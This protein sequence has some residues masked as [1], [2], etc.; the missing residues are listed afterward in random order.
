MYI[1][2]FFAGAA[3]STS[4]V[5]VTT[6]Q[7]SASLHTSIESRRFECVECGQH[8]P[9]ISSLRRHKKTHPPTTKAPDTKNKVAFR[10]GSARK[11]RKM[12]G[13]SPTDHFK[14]APPS[15]VNSQ[16]TSA[17]RDEPLTSFAEYTSASFDDVI[18]ARE[19][20]PHDDQEALS[21]AACNL[22]AFME[23][24]HNMAVEDNIANAS[25]QQELDAAAVTSSR[26]RQP[27]SG[28]DVGSSVVVCPV[29]SAWGDVAPTGLLSL[30]AHALDLERDCFA[31]TSAHSYQPAASAQ[32][33]HPTS[34]DTLVFAAERTADD[35]C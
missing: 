19:L 18:A 10:T 14:S 32:S 9:N 20:P 23:N 25:R 31:S 30:A 21:Q 12:S 5:N 34:F 6:A 29:S 26:V 8:F 1:V 7:H 22:L 13:A 27:S 33:L 16:T 28:D 35:F 17:L 24:Q 2:S 3:R 11:P 15:D 4:V